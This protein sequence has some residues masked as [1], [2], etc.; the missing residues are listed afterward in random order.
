MSR[1]RSF[2]VGVAHGPIEHTER[3]KPL[4][5]DRSG[6]RLSFPH[7]LL[8]EGRLMHRRHS[9]VISQLTLARRSGG[10]GSTPNGS[11]RTGTRTVTRPSPRS[12]SGW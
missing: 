3:V 4:L 12:S 7:G 8:Q 5:L 11:S 10:C 9:P 2:V 1:T 6:G